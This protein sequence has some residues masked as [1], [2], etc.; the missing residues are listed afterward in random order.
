MHEKSGL[1]RASFIHQQQYKPSYLGDWLRRDK[2]V[3]QNYYY[4]LKLNSFIR[5]K[6]KIVLQHKVIA[7]LLK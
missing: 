5:I 6:K 2:M 4:S 3:Y 7:K 1:R